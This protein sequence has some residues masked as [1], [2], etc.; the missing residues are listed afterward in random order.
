VII[1]AIGGSGTRVL[2]KILAAAGGYM[3]R[4]VTR[5]RDSLDLSEFLN[6]H[7]NPVLQRTGSLDYA[8]DGLPPHLRLRTERALLTTLRAYLADRR[9]PSPFWGFKIPRSLYILPFL[10]CLLPQARFIQ[11]VR[12]GRDMAFSKN[13]FQ[14][15]RHFAFLSPP[16]VETSGP[17]AAM[18]LWAKANGEAA[19]WA[20]RHLGDRHR[21]V[22]FEDLC[23]E[24]EREIA[25]LLHW[26]HV[27]ADARDLATLVAA[28]VSL[29]RWRS[30]P[31][32]VIGELERIGAESLGRFGY[33]ATVPRWTTPP[34]LAS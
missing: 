7:L 30:R 11:L 34:R 27:D 9:Q 33:L 17:V 8:L 12:D 26:L 13:S 31:P 19:D 4:R 29:G 5:N 10:D 32:E 2:W 22:R 25:A 16:G 14:L 24:P 3:G 23:A 28:P 18:R 15:D 6:A 21:I 20:T 1:G